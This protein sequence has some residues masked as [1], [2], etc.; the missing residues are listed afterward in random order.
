MSQE[1]YKKGD[2][3]KLKFKIEQETGYDAEYTFSV[4][5]GEIGEITSINNENS[6][7]ESFLIR[8]PDDPSKQ[9][10]LIMRRLV[11]LSRGAFQKV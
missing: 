5:A 11:Y 2:T 6:E 8:F 4:D 1:V 7:F 10:S 3:V 9:G